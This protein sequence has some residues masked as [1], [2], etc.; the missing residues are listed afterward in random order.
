[1][2]PRYYLFDAPVLSNLC[3]GLSSIH[4]QIRMDVALEG[5]NGSFSLFE[6]VKYRAVAS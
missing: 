4:L 5:R 2:E 6:I 1:M 3:L